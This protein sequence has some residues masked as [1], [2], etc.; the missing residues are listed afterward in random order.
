MKKAQSAARGSETTARNISNA[1]DSH[2]SSDSV[3][4]PRTSLQRFNFINFSL[5]HEPPPAVNG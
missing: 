4:F 1:I 5:R 2:T 3:A